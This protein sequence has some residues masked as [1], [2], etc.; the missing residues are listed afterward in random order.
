MGLI[1]KIQQSVKQ[2]KEK[3]NNPEVT[4]APNQL[5]T[6]ELETLLSMIKTSTF[7]GGDIESIYILVAKLQNQYIEQKNK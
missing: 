5:N 1:S 4:P 3:P 2:E 6:R 7:T